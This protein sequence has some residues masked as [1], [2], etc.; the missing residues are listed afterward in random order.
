MLAQLNENISN[1]QGVLDGKL[2][3]M[4]YAVSEN[5]DYTVELSNGETIKIYS[6]KPAEDY[7]CFLLLM[8]NGFIRK[9]MKLIL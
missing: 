9:A 5:G 7:R 3:V 1:Y 2:L 4:G 6:G 8:V